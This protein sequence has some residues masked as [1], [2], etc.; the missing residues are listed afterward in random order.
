MEVQLSLKGYVVTSTSS[1]ADAL[2]RVQKEVFDL[3]LLDLHMPEMNGAEVATRM[4]ALSS[5]P[6]I[7]LLTG[8]SIAEAKA[9]CDELGVAD[10]VTKP[11]QFRDLVACIERIRAKTSRPGL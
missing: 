2:A 7:V 5:P 11:F 9:R 8:D 3:V 1:G 10:C 6:T 4:K